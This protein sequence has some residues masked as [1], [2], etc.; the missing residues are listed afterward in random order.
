ML[1]TLT[2]A[3]NKQEQN[4]HKLSKKSGRLEGKLPV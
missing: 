2:S 1:T 4:E 3:D